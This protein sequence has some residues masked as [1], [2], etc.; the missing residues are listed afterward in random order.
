MVNKTNTILPVSVVI[1]TRNRA[2]VLKKTLS[3]IA[4]QTAQPYEVIIIDASE[5]EDSRQIVAAGIDSIQSK[6]VYKR[7]VVKG[8]ASQRNEGIAVSTQPFIAFMDDDVY[9]EA[10]CFALLWAA[11]N[12]SSDVGGVNALITNQQFHPLGRISRTVYRL[13]T[14]KEQLKNLEGKTIG[15]SVNFLS[16]EKNKLAWIPVDWLNLGLTVYRR[17]ALP[18]PVF[19]PHFTGYSFMEDAALSF[20]VSRKW[21]LYTVRDARIFHDSQPGD[22]K[23]NVEQLAEMEMVNRYYIM[24]RILHKT[25]IKNKVDFIIFQLFYI[26]ASGGLFDF[27]TWKGK[28]KG[29]KKIWINRKR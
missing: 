14:S 27:K 1:P 4:Q 9:L 23:N 5:N 29:I 22:H 12:S 3:T 26:T 16:S 17:A 6:L 11:I 20:V 24:T 2:V 13:F 28:L 21:K 8:A 19:D 10:D 15:P 18:D 25:S 7:A